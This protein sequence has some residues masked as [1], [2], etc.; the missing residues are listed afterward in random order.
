VLRYSCGSTA[1]PAVQLYL[2]Q[3]QPYLN[4]LLCQRARV[5]RLWRSCVVM[6]FSSD[7]QLLLTERYY[8]STPAK[9]AAQ[10]VATASDTSQL[11]ANTL[12]RIQVGAH[13]QV[14][15]HVRHRTSD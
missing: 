1:S 11:Y 10:P 14:Q 2:L 7:A 5:Q 12:S 8:T 6:Q 15:M 4:C 9:R 3:L 13:Q